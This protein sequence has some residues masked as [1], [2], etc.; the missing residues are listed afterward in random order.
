MAFQTETERQTVT[1]QHQLVS[2]VVSKHLRVTVKLTFEFGP[3]HVGVAFDIAGQ[4]VEL[5]FC[6]FTQ[7][8]RNTLREKTQS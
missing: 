6:S 8:Q 5:I 7:T 3:H 1:T 4:R 2:D